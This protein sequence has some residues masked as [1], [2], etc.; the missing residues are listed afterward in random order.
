MTPTPLHA[1]HRLACLTLMSLCAAA[2]HAAPV[3][4]TIDPTH[5]FP[6]FEADH[7]AGMSVWRGKFNQNTGK[8]VLDKAAQTGELLVTID[9]AS[10]D[11]GLD[12]MNEKARSA[13]FFDTAKF[14]TATYKGKLDGWVKGLPTQVTGT[15]SLHGVSK[16]VNLQLLSFKCMPHPMLKRDWCGADALTTINR[17][18][19]GIGA[20]KD[21][22]FDMAVTL[23][24]QVEAVA[25]E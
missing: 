21:W 15:L 17:D 13:E 23:R 12:A 25:A 4:Y 6:S 16:P 2:A 1:G 22:G 24:I 14:P 5:T 11:Y 18:D 8:V 10:I 19:F 3:S 20:G 7:M 9:V